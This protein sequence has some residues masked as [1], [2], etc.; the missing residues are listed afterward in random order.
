MYTDNLSCN[1]RQSFVLA[2][3]HEK[4]KEEIFYSTGVEPIQI[5]DGQSVY[6]KGLAEN[7]K[8]NII[9]PLV[10]ISLFFIGETKTKVCFYYNFDAFFDSSN[11]DYVFF[12]DKFRISKKLDQ[13]NNSSGINSHYP[14]SNIT[15]F[16]SKQRNFTYSVSNK[17]EPIEYLNKK[18][19]FDD[20]KYI[21]LN[22][23]FDFYIFCLNEFSN[24]VLKPSGRRSLFI[25][26]DFLN[27]Y[28]S[29]VANEINLLKLLNS[30]VESRL[31][32]LELY[33]Y[34]YDNVFSLIYKYFN[35]ESI[36]ISKRNI[37]IQQI[38]DVLFRE[39]NRLPIPC[40]Y[41][42]YIGIVFMNGYYKS[43]S[44]NIKD[45]QV[46]GNIFIEYNK[47]VLRR[48]FFDKLGRIFTS[49]PILEIDIILKIGRNDNNKFKNK[50]VLFYLEHPRIDNLFS[51]FYPS[52]KLLQDDLITFDNMNHLLNDSF[53]FISH[54]N[55][56][57]KLE[58]NLLK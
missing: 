57:K 8:Q 6:L 58:Q 24:N 36:E 12:E 23:G 37:F 49:L 7:F 45:L 10:N 4:S 18:V 56:N 30:T 22:S 39:I 53:A 52:L 19:F 38:Q 41:F 51:I 40:K 2:F 17:G 14:N 44:P 29:K 26:D 16:V 27:I 11:F 43:S 13:N 32:F 34:V 20:Q 46:N 33:T 31:Q 28:D 9:S 47:L 25:L 48:E 15:K 21:P 50:I 1:L 55:D 42:N 35:F 3:N 54:V 5:I